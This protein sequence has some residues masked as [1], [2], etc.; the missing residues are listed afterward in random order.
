MPISKGRHILG[1]AGRCGMSYVMVAPET[2]AAAATDLAG[3]GSTLSAAHMAAVPPT[4]AL[5]PAAADEVSAGVAHLFSRYAEGF[6]G[7]AGR[8]AVFHEEFAQHLHAG[9]GS[10]ASAEAVNASSLHPLTA[11]GGLITTFNNIFETLQSLL[12]PILPSIRNFLAPVLGPL[13]DFFGIVFFG[14]FLLAI[15]LLDFLYFGVL[16]KL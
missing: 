16:S 13:F 9:A 2:M 1:L 11:S 14:V 5:V 10:Y 3:I 7:L 8:A 6:Q 4:V 12:R 15:A